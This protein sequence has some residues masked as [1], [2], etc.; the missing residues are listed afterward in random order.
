MQV[1]NGPQ[2]MLFGRNTT[3]AGSANEDRQRRNDL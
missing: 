3:Q 1:L 2:G